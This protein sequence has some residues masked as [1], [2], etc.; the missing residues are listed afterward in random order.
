MPLD[1]D[2]VTGKIHQQER[3][4]ERKMSCVSRYAKHHME[5]DVSGCCCASRRGE[6]AAIAVCWY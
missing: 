6:V 2:N 5:K 3:T 1:A 4:N